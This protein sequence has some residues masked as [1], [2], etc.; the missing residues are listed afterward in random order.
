MA[1][2][3]LV[4]GGAGFIGSALTRFLI[5]ERDD[6]VF[7]LDALTYAGNLN[8]LAPV[9]DDPRFTFLQADIADKQTVA[10][11]I[12]LFAPDRIIHLA[13]ETHVDRSIDGPANFIRTNVVGTVVL[14]QAALDYWRGLQGP[15]RSRFRFL[16]ISTDEVFGSLGAEGRFCE[17]TAYDPRSPYAASKASSDHLVRAWYHTYGLPALI[18][19]CSNNY[20]PYQFPEKLIPLMILNGIEGLPLPV[21]GNGE[22]VRDWVHVED[23]VEAL[24]LVAD[25]GQPG[26][27]YC[28]G[29]DL[30]RPNIDVVRAVCAAL[31]E[32]L[33]DPSIAP[34]HQLISFVEDRPGHDARYAIDSGKMTRALGWQP[35]R[36]FETGLA[37]TVQWYVDNR[38]WWGRIR[39][40]LYRG[41][42][43]GIGAA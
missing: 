2:R 26:E 29:G 8:S 37:E 28:V 35:T 19:N 9:V 39:S 1:R 42:R 4:T 31:D 20:G 24:C 38:R 33:P 6:H 11:A 43:L 23:H 13:A 36:S 18:T 12:G 5:R 14:L 40:G 16:H 30:E 21:Y 15:L 32:L 25:E 41:E 22:N 10:D 7:V 34:R 17:T 3:T 27:T